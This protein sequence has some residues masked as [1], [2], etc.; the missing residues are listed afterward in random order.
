MPEEEVMPTAAE[1]AAIAARVDA[2]AVYYTR[3]PDTRLAPR[4]M[5]QE[6]RNFEY[7]HQR[8]SLDE[9]EV[10]QMNTA[11]RQHEQRVMEEKAKKV[12]RN[13]TG[14]ESTQPT[15]SSSVSLE[16]HANSSSSSI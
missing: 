4:L 9:L 8:R 2:A 14:E 1:M 13:R 15:P 16:E 5:S 12:K 11:M 7:R 6:Q 10:A 3:A